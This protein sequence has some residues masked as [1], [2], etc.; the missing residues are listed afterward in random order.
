MKKSNLSFPDCAKDCKIVILLGCGE[1]ESIC[2]V[3]FNRTMENEKIFDCIYLKSESDYE[4]TKKDLLTIFPNAKIKFVLL[5]VSDGIHLYRL[6][7]ETEIDTMEYRKR[8]FEERLALVSLNFGLWMEMQTKE[9]LEKVK[10]WKKSK[11]GK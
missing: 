4:K 7:I 11:N 6:S 8:I 9:C 3:K 10:E 5:D 2:P 1:C